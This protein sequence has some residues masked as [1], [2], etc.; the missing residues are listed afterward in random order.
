VPATLQSA[1]AIQQAA[2]DA[3]T[4]FKAPGYVVFV[5]EIPRTAS[6]KPQRGEIRQL[7]PRWRASAHCF[8]LRAA[9]RR[10]VPQA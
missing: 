2:L 3:L 5:D 10:P 1:R 7:A 8:D 9:K 6:Q 4:Y